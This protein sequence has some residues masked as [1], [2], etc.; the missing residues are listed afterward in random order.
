ML[1]ISLEDLGPFSQRLSLIA[2][3]EAGDSRSQSKLGDLHRAGDELTQRDYPAALAWY[4]RAA[5]QGAASATNNLGSM[6][7]NG[8]GVR[9]D[10]AVAATWYR[11]AAELGL[12]AAMNGAVCIRH[13]LATW[14]ALMR[15]PHRGPT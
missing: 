9:Q 11:K 14:T 3:A 4:R 8:M 6:Y 13:A 12:A 1:L 15:L 5:E 2:A 10:A 7:L